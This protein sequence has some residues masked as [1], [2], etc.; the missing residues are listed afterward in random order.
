MNF[1]QTYRD[2]RPFDETST[3]F[4]AEFSRA[5][6]YYLRIFEVFKLNFG[7]VPVN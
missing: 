4:F 6:L 2:C 7:H 5:I 3:V 1:N